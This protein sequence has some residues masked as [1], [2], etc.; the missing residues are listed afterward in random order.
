MKFRLHGAGAGST[1]GKRLTPAVLLLAPFLLAYAACSS[2]YRLSGIAESGMTAELRLPPEP[3]STL[4]VFDTAL[5]SSRGDSL[6]VVGADGREMI[7]MRAKRDSGSGEMVAVDRLDAAV[8][9]ARFR[10]VAERN[11]SIRLEFQVIVPEYIRDSD[12]QLRLC[13]VME[14]SGRTFDMDDIIV[15]GENYRRRQLRGYEHYRRFLSRIITDSLEFIDMRNLEIFIARNIPGLYALRNDSSYVSSERFESCFGVTSR[16]AAEHY[17]R[18][19][20]LRRNRRLVADKDRRRRKYVKVPLREEGVRLDT[21]LR[22]GNGDFVYNYVQTVPAA[23]GLRKVGISLS[24]GIYAEDRHLYTIPETD[25]L[26]FYVSSLAGL[27]D[28]TEKYLTK[29][30][31]RNVESNMS[32][33]IDFEAGSCEIDERLGKNGE[34]LGRIRAGLDELLADSSLK[35]DSILV[36][37]SASPE[38]DLKS[39]ISLAYSRA[40]AASEYLSPYFRKLGRSRRDGQEIVFASRSGGENWDL[41]D[42]LV[43]ADSLIS[44]NEKEEYRSLAEESDPDRR[45]LLMRSMKSYPHIHENLYPRLR[46]VDFKFFL[47]REGMLKDT[48]HTSVPDTSYM[49]GVRMLSEHDY[50]GALDRLLPYADYNTAVA[51]AALDR[52]HSALDILSGCPRTARVNYLLALTYSRLGRDREAVECLILA[53]GQDPSFRHRANLDPE[54]CALLDEYELTDK[55]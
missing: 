34:E 51:F 20:L 39:N 14:M 40:L 7:L 50:A 10:N 52:N 15:T 38:G 43:S 17:T 45:E 11:G 25:G 37:A 4:P 36:I 6:L 19:F 31:S 18:K 2:V 55:L 8:V 42:R 48:V 9:T 24:G 21:V 30:I 22:A 16:Q 33:T 13:P 3:V 41:L 47:H 23:P 26:T 5:V 54:I 29:I 1:A 44:R 49:A 28:C 12:W 53:C 46:T 32:C 27:A 35:V